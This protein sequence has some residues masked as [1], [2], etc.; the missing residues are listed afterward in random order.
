MATPIGKPRIR[1]FM[2]NGVRLWWAKAEGERF[3]LPGV[4]LGVSPSDAYRSWLRR[5][6]IERPMREAYAEML[7]RR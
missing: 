2:S 4:A 3:Y 6:E 5:Q 7:G 1:P